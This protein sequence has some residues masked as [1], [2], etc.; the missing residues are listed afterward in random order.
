MATIPRSIQATTTPTV[1]GGRSAAGFKNIANVSG[2]SVSDLSA[3]GG[4]L[5]ESFAQEFHDFAYG[6]DK[7]QQQ[8]TPNGRPHLDYGSGTDFIASFEKSSGNEGASEQEG[9]AKSRFLY[10]L[11]M[12]AGI[13]ERNSQAGIPDTAPRGETF[14]FNL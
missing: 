8:F 14:N 1:V 12:V 10:K 9:A 2:S 4:V 3:S 6:Q 7:P 11:S 5:A 13:Y